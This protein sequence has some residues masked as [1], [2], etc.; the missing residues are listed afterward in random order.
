[1][2]IQHVNSEFLDLCAICQDE[3]SVGQELSSLHPQD[4]HVHTF[5]QACINIWLQMKNT[6]PIC[7]KITEV[8]H[9]AEAVHAAAQPIF[10]QQVN[11]QLLGSRARIRLGNI[12]RFEQ[13][14]EQNNLERLSMI[15]TSEIPVDFIADQLDHA[16]T[17]GL[18]E[19][20]SL[21]LRRKNLGK[22]HLKRAMSAASR[23]GNVEIA[24]IIL[25]K[26]AFSQDEI[27]VFKRLAIRHHHQAIVELIDDPARYAVQQPDLNTLDHYFNL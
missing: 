6:C 8:P 5:H 24:T 10:N 4:E 25:R 22:L 26:R 13:A 27:A 2:S 21:I 20:A 19:V 11:I 14:L 17:T 18:Q 15:L 7:R 9:Q 12:T 23:L 3:M 1:M 16:I